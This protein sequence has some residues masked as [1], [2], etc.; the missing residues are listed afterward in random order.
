VEKGIPDRFYH[1]RIQMMEGEFCVWSKGEGGFVPGVFSGYGG[2]VTVNIPSSTNYPYSV[3]YSSS[4][5]SNYNSSGYPI[6]GGQGNGGI[7]ASM[8]SIEKLFKKE[9]PN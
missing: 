7:D 3:G 6:H 1:G 9:K 4:G 8:G 2:M 5:L